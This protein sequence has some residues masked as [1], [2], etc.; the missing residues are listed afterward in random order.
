MEGLSTNSTGSRKEENH[1]EFED[2]LA[3]YHITIYSITINSQLPLG[4]PDIYI[5]LRTLYTPACTHLYA[6][7]LTG[8]PH[9]MHQ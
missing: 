1:D 3:I 5:T 9:K 4:L 6:L 7:T 8:H 2:I